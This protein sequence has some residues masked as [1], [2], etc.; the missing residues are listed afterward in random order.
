[1]RNFRT[2]RTRGWLALALLWL[3]M[4]AWAADAQPSGDAPRS[5]QAVTGLVAR[6]YGEE[7]HR[8]PDADGLKMHAEL[9]VQSGHDEAWLRAALRNS[10]EG[11]GQRAHVRMQRTYLTLLVCALAGLLYVGYR[12][13]SLVRERFPAHYA[14]LLE[15]ARLA[16]VS[17][18]LLALF[19]FENL[20]ATGPD[21]LILTGVLLV[22]GLHLLRLPRWLTYG[23]SLA[24]LIGLF[25]F[26]VFV[27][28]QGPQDS[29]SDRNEAVEIAARA[30]L[31]GENPWSSRSVLGLP[32]TTGPS[33]ILTAL[34]FVKATGRINTLT[35][36]YW[37][38]FLG[39]LLA[40]DLLRRNASFVLLGLLLLSPWTG[41]L[42]TLHWSLDELYY[43]AI[44]LPVL[45]L[46]LERRWLVW[47]GALMGFMLFSR[48]VY[49]YGLAGVGLWWLGQ[50][51]DN[52]KALWRIAAGAGLYL[53]ATLFIFYL[54][55]GHAFLTA[56][57]WKNSQMTG[58]V[59]DANWLA[60][61]LSWLRNLTQPPLAYLLV[62]LLLAPA[63][64]LLRRVRHPFYHFALGVFLA[65]TVAFAPP[66][67][68]DYALLFVI[69]LC[70]AIAFRETPAAPA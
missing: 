13:R 16:P 56:N 49:A 1:M 68:A 17:V 45:W 57:F 51:R 25:G 42:H 46:L 31:H 33:S 20:K 24:G 28:A 55:G 35:F 36:G 34:P 8:A 10:N 58:L 66:A 70:Y 60:A 54:I 14:Y 52:W 50:H 65:C 22:A 15:P 63:S 3:G 19:A 26:Y 39:L 18:L 6:V 48:L 11:R 64:L 61:S 69:P 4:A 62:C 23:V 27:D 53:A 40:G 32:I 59:S 12:A 44:L 29:F 38:L 30:A 47:A 5:W 43:A 2:F 7:L 67:P 41:F 21:S 9:L 37:M